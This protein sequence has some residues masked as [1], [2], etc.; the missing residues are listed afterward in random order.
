MKDPDYETYLEFRRLRPDAPAAEGER[1][2]GVPAKKVQKWDRVS[3]Q[4]SESLLSQ[5]MS[6]IAYARD[7]AEEIED[8]E[9][10]A[11]LISKLVNNQVKLFQ[12]LNQANSDVVAAM[13]REAIQ[14]NETQ[15]TTEVMEW[16]QTIRA[17]AE[18][19]N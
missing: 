8:S 1:L 15:E 16:I 9:K 13:I 14:Q 6:D 10:K 5:I 4:H 18:G 11:S 7:I 19:V 2:Y 3:V 12:V 17:K